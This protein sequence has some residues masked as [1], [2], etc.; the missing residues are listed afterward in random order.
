MNAITLTELF[1]LAKIKETAK[2]GCAPKGLV[3]HCLVGEEVVL[4][5]QL[6]EVGQVVEGSCRNFLQLITLQEDS[7]SASGSLS[8]DKKSRQR[9][10]LGWTVGSGTLKC[11][12]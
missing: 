3:V 12:R 1:S 7:R 5:V 9:K 2:G 4:K 8:T 11:S 10:H 6:S